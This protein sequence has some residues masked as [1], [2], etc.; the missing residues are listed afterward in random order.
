MEHR[1]QF[2]IQMLKKKNNNNNNNEKKLSVLV[3]VPE[4]RSL[5][6]VVALQR[7]ATKFHALVHSHGIAH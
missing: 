5:I 2:E 3:R 7:T 1:V 6:H 4:L